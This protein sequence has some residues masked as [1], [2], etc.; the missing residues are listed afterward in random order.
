MVHF[1]ANQTPHTVSDWLK[2]G[3]G[4]SLIGRAVLILEGVQNWNLKL[5]PK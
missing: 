3:R 2:N 4:K 1:R 5:A